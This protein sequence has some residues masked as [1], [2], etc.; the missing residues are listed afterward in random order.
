MPVNRGR[1]REREMNEKQRRG[2]WG[3]EILRYG[4]IEN[5]WESTGEGGWGKDRWVKEELSNESC[6]LSKV[7]FPLPCFSTQQMHAVTPDD[8]WPLKGIRRANAELVAHWRQLHP[9]R[10]VGNEILCFFSLRDYFQVCIIESENIISVCACAQ[11]CLS[12]RWSLF[13]SFSERKLRY[14]VLTK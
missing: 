10:K 4:E 14:L 6:C 12:A 2:G 13:V 3:D 9:R 11:T 8:L 5:V 1:E 7:F